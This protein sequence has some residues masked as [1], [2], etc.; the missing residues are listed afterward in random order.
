MGLKP[1]K[2]VCFLERFREVVSLNYFASFIVKE[3]ELIRILDS[4]CHDLEIKGL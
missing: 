3:G 2:R 1:I 4:L